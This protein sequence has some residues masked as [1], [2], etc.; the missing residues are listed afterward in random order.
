VEQHYSENLS[1][2]LFA[3][4]TAVPGYN[5]A[6]SE[7]AL[8][9]Y[10]K[11]KIN[12]VIKDLLNGCD[13]DT[14]DDAFSL[15]NEY[16]AKIGEKGLSAED[17][18]ELESR[19]AM[20]FSQSVAK[21]AVMRDFHALA[22]YARLS[23]SV[24]EYIPPEESED[25]GTSEDDSSP[26]E[27]SE[28]SAEESVPEEESEVRPE[29]GPEPGRIIAYIFVGVTLAAAVAALAVGIVRKNKAAKTKN[30]EKFNTKSRE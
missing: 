10:S 11:T 7:K 19:M 21:S 24:T 27:E 3:E 23:K 4:K 12:S 25:P 15:I 22:K 13:E 18:E 26:V 1:S 30:R 2:G 5:A 20:V 28:G 6:E 17:A 16:R 9:D 14:V 29:E 8:L